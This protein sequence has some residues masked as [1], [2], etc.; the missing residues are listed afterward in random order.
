[1]NNCINPK[2]G[3]MLHAY[4]LKQLPEK[5]TEI[6]ELH[7]LECAECFEKVGQFEKIA[8][9]MTGNREVR[10]TIKGM[11]FEEDLESGLLKRILGSLW[12]NTRLFLKPAIGY[13]MILVLAYPAYLGIKGQKEGDIRQVETL[14]LVPNRSVSADI[15][16]GT[17]DILLSFVFRGAV[18]GGSYSVRLIDS[19]GKLIYKNDNFNDFDNYEV[20]RLVFTPS[21]VPKGNYILTIEDIG[22]ESPNSKQEYSFGI[23]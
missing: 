5:E 13:L 4:E 17:S 9:I 15:E 11:K 3:D 8:D 22:G 19:N 20:G 16:A 2:I 6:F 18:P 21:S 14:S 10:E 7:L 12:P 23:K 1:M